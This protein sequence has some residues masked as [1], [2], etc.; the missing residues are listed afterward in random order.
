MRTRKSAPTLTERQRH[1]QIIGLFASHLA[2]MPLAMSRPAAETSNGW[3]TGPH[4]A[5]RP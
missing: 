4:G 2:S 3:F 1:R 5:S